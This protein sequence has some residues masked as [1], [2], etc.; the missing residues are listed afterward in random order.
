MYAF[1]RVLA[2]GIS[3]LTITLAAGAQDQ[4]LVFK[5]KV[6]VIMVPVVVRD[7]KGKVVT[8][9]HQEDF[10]LFDRRR[11]RWLA[12]HRSRGPASLP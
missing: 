10:E 7:K 3:L 6:N 4:P 5:T 2:L 8:T 11:F 1:R 12:G 9:L